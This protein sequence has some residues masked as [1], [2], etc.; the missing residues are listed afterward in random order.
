[1]LL[2]DFKDENGKWVRSLRIGGVKFLTLSGAK[3][4]SICARCK[5]D[6]S[7]QKRHPTY[8]GASNKFKDFQDFTEWSTKQV[9]Y[10]CGWNLDK[11]LLYKRN[12]VYSEAT[13]VF[14]PTEINAFLTKHDNARGNCPI[15]VHWD[16]RKTKYIAQCNNFR[17][18]VCIGGF[19]T[20]DLAFNAYK[21]YKESRSKTLAAEWVGKVDQRV[22][23]A[24]NAYEVEITD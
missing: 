18:R 24:L 14:I 22:I 17:R 1:M 4:N 8:I 10:N 15:G 13:C 6:G 11:D 7:H 3:W 16:A 20:P 5:A 23:D 19:A 21:R 9:G 2:E 12:K